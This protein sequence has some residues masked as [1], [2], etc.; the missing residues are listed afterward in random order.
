MN[1][2]LRRRLRERTIV[3]E[4]GCHEWQGYVARNG[5]GQIG[6]GRKVLYTHRAAW[7]LAHSDPGEAYVL[8]KCDN[9]RCVNPDHL[10]LGDHDSN[11]GDMV[12]KKRHAF[13]ERNGLSILTTD[14]VREIKASKDR[15][16][17]LAER[18]GV[19][20]STISC[21][22]SGVNWAHA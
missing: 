17:D 10:F 21:I 2:S 9:R 3:K 15:T 6:L 18:Y 1:E 22:K 4:N 12:K 16:T 13:G 5:Y 7:A 20:L 11:M 8:H 14:Q 19:A